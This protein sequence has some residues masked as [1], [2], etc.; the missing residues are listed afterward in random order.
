MLNQLFNR[1]V[2]SVELELLNTK[3]PTGLGRADSDS[4]LTPQLELQAGFGE[5]RL[6]DHQVRC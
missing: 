1:G 3:E 5:F 4:Y 6:L 2:D